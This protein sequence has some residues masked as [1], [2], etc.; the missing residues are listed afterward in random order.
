MTITIHLDVSRM[1]GHCG[2]CIFYDPRWR[3]AQ[4]MLCLAIV[5]AS[6][7]QQIGNTGG[8]IAWSTKSYIYIYIA[9]EWLYSF[10][11]TKYLSS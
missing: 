5:Y 11:Q 1:R 7:P 9:I 2:L 8:K 4:T 6:L 10:I 3:Q